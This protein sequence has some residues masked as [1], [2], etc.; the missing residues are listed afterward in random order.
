MAHVGNSNTWWVGR[1]ISRD[2]GSVR[3]HISKSKVEKGWRRYPVL[4]SGMYI[5]EYTDTHSHT[6]THAQA[7]TLTHSCT[8]AQ[9]HPHSVEL[10]RW[11]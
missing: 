1:Y 5:R 9:T 11:G 4:N 3:N 8:H 10:L 7:H 2:L 6:Y